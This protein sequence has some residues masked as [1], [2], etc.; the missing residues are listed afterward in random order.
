[1]AHYYFCVSEVLPTRYT[2]FFSYIPDE[3][4]S[5]TS[6]VWMRASH[7]L[8][9]LPWSMPG[10]SLCS[11]CHISPSTPTPSPACKM[12]AAVVLLPT[13]GPSWNL[14]WNAVGTG[15]NQ[16]LLLQQ[17][18]LQDFQPAEQV[19]ACQKSNLVSRTLGEN[20]L[21]SMLP[22]GRSCRVQRLLRVGGK[23]QMTWSPLIS[24]ACKMCW[25]GVLSVGF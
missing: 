3:M 5:D 14:F 12:I 13:E 23:N 18:V 9:P 24:F 17:C 20:M 4:E 2:F 15:G 16:Q 21:P 6:S 19:C 1:M 22:S 7:Q 25:S 8:S 11:V 10:K